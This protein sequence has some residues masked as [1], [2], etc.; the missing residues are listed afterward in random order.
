MALKSKKGK[1]LQ[2]T[3]QKIDSRDGDKIGAWNG[4]PLRLA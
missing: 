3:V 4:C 2:S 1:N